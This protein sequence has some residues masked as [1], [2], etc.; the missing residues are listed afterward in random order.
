MDSIKADIRQFQAFRISIFVQRFHIWIVLH[1]DTLI[2]DFARRGN[3]PSG[4]VA[5]QGRL[6]HLQGEEAEDGGGR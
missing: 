3:L 5:L 6:L 2:S 4:G 1:V